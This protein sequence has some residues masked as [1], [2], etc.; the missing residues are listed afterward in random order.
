MVRDTGARPFWSVMI[1]TYERSDLLVY[2]VESVLAQDHGPDRMQIEVVDNYSTRVDVA[3]IVAQIGKGRVSHFRQTENV[4]MVRNWNTCISRATGQWVHILNDD[5]GVM[6]GYYAA[7][8]RLIERYPSAL[9]A[10]GPAIYIDPKG[11]AIGLS[12]LPAEAEGPVSDFPVRHALSNLL[13]TPAFVVRRT[14]YEMVGGFDLGL[15]YCP[16]WD[17]TF[18]LALAGE[19]VV[20]T[21]PYALYRVHTANESRVLAANGLTVSEM[22]SLIDSMFDRL[23][24][25]L[26]KRTSGNR[27]AWA[28]LCARLQSGTL[29]EEGH[30]R[31]AY[32][33]AKMGLRL[34]PSAR[35]AAHLMRLLLRRMMSRKR[36]SPHGPE[37]Q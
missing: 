2:A 12:A 11:R 6:P 33:L 29:A 32:A 25:H 35:Y 28:A 7:Y 1:P 36:P 30:L 27:Y 13:H 37:T 4:G 8:E 18:R 10:G 3:K 22:V 16:D 21:V 9:M 5:D 19:V 20:S 26:S 31:E 24:K 17:M 34:D 15:R 23:P 14:G